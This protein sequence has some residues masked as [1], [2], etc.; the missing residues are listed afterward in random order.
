MCIEMRWI[1]TQLFSFYHLV[2]YFL[3]N[4]CSTG[5]LITLS[6]DEYKYPFLFTSPGTLSIDVT[7]PHL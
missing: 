6:T 3:F 5:I 4:F 2:T 7:G 1:N